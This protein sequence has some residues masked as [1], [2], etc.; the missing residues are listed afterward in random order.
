MTTI[1]DISAK[2][3]NNL[4]K[5][6]ED[7]TDVGTAAGAASL[8]YDLLTASNQNA[9]V[10]SNI[11]G[12]EVVSSA[13]K[14]YR[15]D[16]TVK[17]T[18]IGVFTDKLDT[19]GSLTSTTGGALLIKTVT[20]VT[21]DAADA[22]FRN[23]FSA[24]LSKRQ[25]FEAS[26]VASEGLADSSVLPLGSSTATLINDAG[27]TLIKRSNVM[28][29]NA[30]FKSS[31]LED[32]TDNLDLANNIT[33][34]EILTDN[35][36]KP[37]IPA[38]SFE[39]TVNP[40]TLLQTFE[41]MEAY[42]RSSLRDFTEVVVHATDT[43]KDMEVN[44]DVLKAWDVTER[45]LS[46]V[47]YHFIILRDGS[48]QVCRPISV[49]GI[50]SLKGHNENSIGIAFVGGLLGNRSNREAK[51]SSRSFS[52]EQFNTFDTFMKAFYTVVPGGQ[53]W[54]HNDIDHTRRSDPHF[55]VPR[56][57]RNKFNKINVQTVKQT[58][59]NGSLTIDQLIEAQS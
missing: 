45:G 15:E 43:T 28:L 22:A 29:A 4:G 23:S 14:R 46:E 56:Y 33:F 9:T 5:L 2:L 16:G 24:A 19:F 48:L 12:I 17:N 40:R 13:G 20:G 41:E 57:L 11:N 39:D 42:L 7:L 31:I 25:M 38:I 55:N 54:G 53:V 8:Q 51:R 50:H 21:A 44:Y 27:S 10:G 26:L 3:A 34:P 6:V 58:R 1:G 52:M 35:V 36:G 18:A 49:D 37:S 32:I 47:G 59:E 30:K